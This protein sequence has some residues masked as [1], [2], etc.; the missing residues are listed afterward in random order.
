M[1]EHSQDSAEPGWKDRT[2]IFV[3]SFT[4]GLMCA[5]GFIILIYGAL[6][7]LQEPFIVGAALFLLGAIV[8]QWGTFFAKVL[9][10]L[11][12]CMCWNEEASHNRTRK[13]LEP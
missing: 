7:D 12:F 8:M 13:V 2:L 9:S 4:S 11:F 10:F 5:A 3:L 6:Q 1:T